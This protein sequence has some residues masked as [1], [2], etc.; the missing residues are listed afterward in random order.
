MAANIP[1]QYYIP[2]TPH[3][4]NSELPVLVYRN[5][6]PSPPDEPTVSEFL[7]KHEWEKK[8]C[9]HLSKRKEKKTPTYDF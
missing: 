8:V 4:P 5:I 6:L 7:Q 3:C 9:T 1:E 2:T